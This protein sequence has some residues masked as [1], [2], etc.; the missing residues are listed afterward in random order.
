MQADYSAA[1][2]Y[3]ITIYHFVRVGSRPGKF[4]H[5]LKDID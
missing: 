3:F 1:F 2:N 4:K 5:G